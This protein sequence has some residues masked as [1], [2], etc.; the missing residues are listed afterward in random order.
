[1]EPNYCATILTKHFKGGKILIARKPISPTYLPLELNK[2]ISSNICGL[3][4]LDTD[5]SYS[6]LYDTCSLVI[7]HKMVVRLLSKL[8]KTFEL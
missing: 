3:N 6:L 1:M 7:Y 8:S 5:D 2:D 4:Q